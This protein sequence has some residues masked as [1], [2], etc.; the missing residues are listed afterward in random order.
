[1]KTSLIM[2]LFL[3]GVAFGQSQNDLND[4]NNPN[5]IEELQ[6]QVTQLKRLND[7]QDKEIK[8]LETANK[9]LTG[10]V[11]LLKQLCIKLG[12]TP[13]ET[14]KELSKQIKTASKIIK[15]KFDTPFKI[16]QAARLGGDNTLTLKIIQIQDSNNMLADYPILDVEWWKR[17]QESYWSHE[18]IWLKGIST[19]GLAD[20]GKIDIVG[21]LGITGTT[22]YKLAQGGHKTV[23]VFE[24]I[25]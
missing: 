24:L 7:A 11:R 18:T 14:N 10:H 23:F 20:D 8:K 15:N 19:L 3:L 17:H 22:T 9:Q 1:M 16:G 12:F 4:P 5:N 21:I 2:M 6:R 13:E 25:I